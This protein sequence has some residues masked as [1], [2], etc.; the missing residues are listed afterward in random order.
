MRIILC[1]NG[2]PPFPQQGE[3]C[4]AFSV[5][6][7]LTI[8]QKIVFFTGWYLATS[9]LPF[10][11]RAQKWCS[12]A[13]GSKAPEEPHGTG[14]ALPWSLGGTGR[15]RG[16]EA[17]PGGVS[18]TSKCWDLFGGARS[19]HA[20][21]KNCGFAWAMQI[22]LKT[23]RYHR[24]LNWEEDCGEKHKANFSFAMAE[25]RVACWLQLGSFLQQSK[26]SLT[27]GAFY[28]N[29]CSYTHFFWAQG[30]FCYFCALLRE[31]CRQI[32]L[33]SVIYLES[34][35]MVQASHLTS[36]ISSVDIFFGCSHPDSLSASRKN[37][38]SALLLNAPHPPKNSFFWMTT[39][40]S[41]S[42]R[43]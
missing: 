43:F 13:A 7:F 37:S 31:R 6:L 19:R 39:G 27:S 21:C 22:L 9:S 16:Q 5:Y 28:P 25:N 17:W 10:P 29:L 35:F 2:H 26:A 15:R 33:K 40:E 24:V 42:H 3:E 41:Q 1:Q 32:Y 36:N 4:F 38:T 8:M 30:V 14:R 11:E 23:K 20:A 12:L 18:N 34:C